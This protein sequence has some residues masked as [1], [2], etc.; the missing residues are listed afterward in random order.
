MF[1][2][3]KLIDFIKIANTADELVAHNGDKFDIKKLRTRCIYHRIPM[4]PKYQSLDTLKKAKDNFSFISNSLNAI[5][6]Y[7]GLGSKMPH[8][9]FGL[10]IKCMRKVP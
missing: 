6:N 7:L 10:W 2:V 3:V 1:L 8:E 9:G 4:F 5:A